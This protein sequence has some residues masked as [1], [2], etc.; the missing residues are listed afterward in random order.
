[1]LASFG[2]IELR[3]ERRPAG[4]LNLDVEVARTRSIEAGH[5]GVKLIPSVGASEHVAAQAKARIVVLAS[6]VSVP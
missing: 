1:L 4:R 3:G 2:K 6:I 5:E